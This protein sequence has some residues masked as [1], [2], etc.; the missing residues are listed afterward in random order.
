MSTIFKM[1]GPIS[2]L[3]VGLK[4]LRQ[5]L[6]IEPERRFDAK[7]Q[8]YRRC[9]QAVTSIKLPHGGLATAMAYDM[10][11]FLKTCVSRCLEAAGPNDVL[12]NYSTTFL[13]E[14]HRESSA[15]A[16][17]LGP[18]RQWPWCYHTGPPASFIQYSSVDNLPNR[19]KAKTDQ[20]AETAV[21]AGEVG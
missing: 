11:V 17:G 15:G 8:V 4:L 3:P 5:G 7:G 16:P 9:R 13:A 1:A 20:S 21:V 10:W 6:S 19:R 18:V 14:D 2:I 12:Q